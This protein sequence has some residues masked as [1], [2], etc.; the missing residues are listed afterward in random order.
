[1]AYTLDQCIMNNP[2]LKR[3]NHVSNVLQANNIWD[4]DDFVNNP[5]PTKGLWKSEVQVLIEM[6]DKEQR[7]RAYQ[8]RASFELYG[9]LAKYFSKHETSRVYNILT[10]HRINSVRVFLSIRKSE[11]SAFYGI[12]P[13]SLEKLMKAKA[14][15]WNK[16]AELSTEAYGRNR[17][18]AAQPL[19]AGFN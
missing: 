11:L 2:R 7:I 14:D 6:R 12:G 19:L 4:W 3:R 15:L 9:I 10:S 5:I 18:Y 8:Q 17:E 13:I 16:A 1:M